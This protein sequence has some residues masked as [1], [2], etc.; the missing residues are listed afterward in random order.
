MGCGRKLGR[1][2]IGARRLWQ[3]NGVNFTSTF[4]RPRSLYPT[5]FD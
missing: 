4:R 2:R 1:T 5:F 3:E